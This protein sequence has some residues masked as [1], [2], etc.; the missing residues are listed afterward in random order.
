MKK[1]FSQRV[2]SLGFCAILAMSSIVYSPKNI[3]ADEITSSVTNQALA[4]GITQAPGNNIWITELYPNDVDRSATYVSKSDLMEFV[5]ITNTGDVDLDFNNG[6]GLYYEYPSGTSTVMKELTVTDV[7]GNAA[8]TIKAGE[9]VVIWSKRSDIAT[10]PTESQFRAAMNI[11]ADVQVL[12]CSGQNGF[13][14]DDRGFAI[15]TDAGNI[16]SYFHYTTAIDTADGLAVNLEIPDFGYEMLPFEQLKPTSAG[17]AYYS[18]LNGRGN[19]TIPADTTPNGLYITEIRPNDSNRDAKFGSGVND[20]MECL[21]LTNTTDKDIDLNKEYELYFVVKET[22]KKK[23][24][25]YK[26]DRTSTECIIPAGGTAVIWCDRQDSLVKGTDY[27]NWPTEE[28]FRGAY[29]IPDSSPVFVFTNQ[30]G[31]TN[32]Q[33]GFELRKINNDKTTTIVSNYFWDGVSDVIDNKSVQ[34]GVNPEGPEMLVYSRSVAST[35]G[36][37]VEDQLKYAA[38]DKSFPE[39]NLL[40][41]SNTVNQGDFFRIPYYYA[42]TEAMPV[43]SIELYYKTSQMNN[44]EC[45]KTTSFAIY[46]KYYAFIPSD[47]VLNAEYVDYYVKANNAYHSTMT[48]VH[49]ISMNKVN[50]AEGLRVNIDGKTAADTNSVSGIINI[51]AKNFADATPNISANLDGNELTTTHSLEK[52]AFYTFSYA[53]IDSYFK[54]ALTCGD[55]IIKLMANCSE[56]PTNSSMAILVDSYNFTYKEDGSATVEL[57]IRTGTYG[58]TWESDTAANN[59]DFSINSI[60][61]SLTDGTIIYPTTFTNEKGESLNYMGSTKM[62]DSTGCNIAAK[63]IFDI[64]LAKVDATAM[65]IDTTK[66]SDGVHNLVVKSGDVSKII[67]INVDNSVKVIAEE[68]AVDYNAAISVDAV[69]TQ[70]TA[71]VSTTQEAD[72]VSVY[73][74]KMLADMNVYEGSGDSTYSAVAESGDKKTTSDNGELPYQIY[75]IATD[76]VETESIRFEVNAVSDYGRDVQVYALNVENNKWEL[77]ESE[78]QDNKI[79]VIFPLEDKI[80]GGKVKVLVQA[81]GDEYTPYTNED[82]KKTVADNYNWD[83][84]TVPEQYDFSLAWITDTQYYSEQYMSNFDSMTDWIINKQAE[85]GIEYVIH[86]GDIVDEFN[87]EYEFVNASNEL[88]KFEDAGIPYGVLGGN[89]DVAHGNERFELYNKYFGSIRYKDMSS[90]GDSYKDNLGHYDLLTIDGQELLFVYMSWDIYTPEVDWMNDVLK[91]YPDR[92]AVICIH[93]GINANAE[94]SYFSN[95]LLDKVCKENTNVLAILNGHYHGSSMNFVGFDDNGDGVNDRTVYQICTDY[96]SAPEGGQGYIKMLYF[97]LAND[98]IYLNS[99]SPVLDDMNYYDTPKL[100]GYDAGTIASNIDIT[101][102]NVDFDQNTVKTLAVSEVKAS[103]L[104][105]NV[106]GS[107]QANGNTIVQLKI[108]ESKMKTVYAKV[109]DAEGKTVAYSALAIYSKASDQVVNDTGGNGEIN[110]YLIASSLPSTG[111]NNSLLFMFILLFGSGI[112]LTFVTKKNKWWI[113]IEKTK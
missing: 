69:S 32:T 70:A 45:V 93:G 1:K 82:T 98:K 47:I 40:D 56:I 111:D 72:T 94:Q 54:N 55:K 81:R 96:Q 95:L 30:N 84:T 79:T 71:A 44:Y 46:N 20:V 16:V 104:T 51:T 3:I 74:A 87:E 86:T 76:G 19:I 43:K 73:E 4:Q 88:K 24:P 99:Y 64:P 29:A 53:G 49:R 23:L 112:I 105:N 34:L 57:A 52:G 28:E 33:R 100:S 36:I 83:G 109:L 41:D 65:T 80:M 113:Q 42:G 17:I 68:K 66:L 63:A 60:A 9:T 13:A 85:M 27:N 101:E 22:S 15:K 48:E 58:S 92:K 11:A 103:L 90:Y 67:S 107:E 10:G 91:K 110:Q 38:D 108:G 21:E 106:L 102:L 12:I 78:K 14:E 62:G 6:Y 8:V 35:M 77:L 5:E 50:N 59:D 97:D 25:L 89:H 61:L 31:L 7:L 39:L 37:V 75:E 2:I 18:Q 26:T